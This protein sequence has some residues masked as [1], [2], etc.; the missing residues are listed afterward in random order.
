ME[1]IVVGMV[2][3]LDI[4]EVAVGTAVVGNNFGIEADSIFGLVAD[5]DT[6]RLVALAGNIV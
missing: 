2:A 5:M 1:E 6:G 4:V 3:A